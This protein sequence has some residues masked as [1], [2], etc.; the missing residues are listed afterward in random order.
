M[1][2]RGWI[3]EVPSY[4]YFSTWVM[5]FITTI[6]FVYLYNLNRPTL[7]VQFYLLSLAIKV[8]AALA[9]CLV[10]VLKDPQGSAANVSYFFALYVVFTALEI[11]LLYRKIGTSQ[12]P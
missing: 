2:L 5:A 7:F 6:I 8:M 11:V 10:M 9:Y 1:W 3:A 12:R 4:M